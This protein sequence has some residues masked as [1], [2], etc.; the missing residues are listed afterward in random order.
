M[1]IKPKPTIKTIPVTEIS[2]T[3]GQPHAN[4]L[5]GALIVY[6]TVKFTLGFRLDE[7]E[8]HVGGD[9]AIHRVSASSDKSTDW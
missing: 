4:A 2:A 7:E 1:G 9:I 3:V 6:G 5:I 8:E